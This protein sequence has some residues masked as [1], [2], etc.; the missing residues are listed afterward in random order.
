VAEARLR[1]LREEVAALER[2]R[3]VVPVAMA[4]EEGKVEDLRVHVRGSHLNLG[5]VVP[6]R[7]PRALAGEGQAPI[8]AKQSGRLQLAEWLTRPDHPLTARVFVNRVWLGH[9]GEGLVR[10]PDNFGRLGERPA[11]QPLLDWLAV[12][13]VR[14]GW[15][16]KR[17]HR[18]ILLSGAY[19]MSTAYDARAAQADA[20]NRLH[21]RM[22]RRRMEAEQLR[23]SLL[24]VS[25][26][27]DRTTGG[28]L[29]TVPDHHYVS[30]SA[31]YDR[32]DSPRRSLYLPVIRSDVYSV[33][34]AFDFAD[35][36]VPN[37]RRDTTT[38]APQAL[39]MLNG[40][41][42]REESARLAQTLLAFPCDDA[43]RVS[44][45]CERLYSR[46]ASGHDVD[47]AL[48]FLRRYEE[49]LRGQKV[50]DA[51]CRPRAWQ[52]LCRVLL[53]SNEFIFIE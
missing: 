31:R 29:L 47:R 19:Q 14:D 15:S 17:L 18:L 5:P 34:Q 42:A 30:V 44:A 53:A 25:G 2:S 32:Y 39:F 26:R 37:G 51:E 35:P 13:F 28:S 43:G 41:L 49:T 1:K 48:D 11:N 7:F 36:S 9:F 21:W 24:A 45:A 23:D 6:R 12:R 20:D 52:G 10:T 8:D 50:A 16:V 4:V 3:P 38:V 27:L 22:N 46:P 40:K 33:F